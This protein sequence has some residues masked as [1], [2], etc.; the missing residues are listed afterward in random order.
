MIRG[1]IQGQQNISLVDGGATHNFI[2]IELVARQALQTEE[3]EGFDVAVAD[4]HTVECV[5][6]IPDL[7]VK[8]GNYT[9]R[10]I[11]YVFYLSHTNF[12]LGFQWLITLGNISTNYQ[13]L[14]MGFRDSEGKRI[15]LKGISTGAPKIVLE[16]R[17]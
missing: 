11:F 7:E 17:M 9:M 2:D 6:R 3:F 5:D 15:I 10:D 1:T 12:M 16:K 14:E 8:L 4:S 13:N